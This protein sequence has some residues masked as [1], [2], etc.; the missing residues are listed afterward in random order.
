MFRRLLP[1]AA[2]MPYVLLVFATLCWAGNFILARAMHAEI[3]PV[4]LA[5]G[6]WLVALLALLPIAWPRIMAQ[7]AQLWRARRRLLWLGAYGIAASNTLIYIGLHHT[8]ATNAVLFNALVPLMV[9]LLAWAVWR[10]PLAGREWAGVAGSLMGVLLII[11]HG[12][13]GHLLTLDFNGG[14]AWVVGGLACWSVYTLM[15]RGIRDSL[16]RFAV[17]AVTIAVGL[18]ML[19]P[20]LAWEVMEVGLP[21]ASAANGLS[22]LYLGLFPSVFALIAYMRAVSAMGPT[23][24]AGFLHLIPAFGAVGAGIFLGEQLAAYHVLGL[25]IIF[26]GLYWAQGAAPAVAAPTVAPVRR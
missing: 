25:A 19:L 22:V 21:A 15:L 18:V 4:T 6:R 14:D 17:L 23:R 7:R 11:C 16:D 2:A 24:A 13:L 10:K 26:C 8:N 12:Q 5:F 20:F 3:A 1:S 9:M